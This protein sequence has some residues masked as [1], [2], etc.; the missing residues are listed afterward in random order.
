MKSRKSAHII[1]DEEDGGTDDEIYHVSG[2][3]SESTITQYSIQQ[4]NS[5]STFGVSQSSN[6]QD[7]NSNITVRV[8]QSGN[9]HYSKFDATSLVAHRSHW[10]LS[11]TNV[12]KTNTKTI[13]YISSI[14]IK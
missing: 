2:L 10:Y 6:Q 5:D 1:A 7:D 11:E 13:I 9:Q 4:S 14:K 12:T 8:I 3:F